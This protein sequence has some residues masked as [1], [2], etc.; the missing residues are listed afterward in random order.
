MSS[1][2]VSK[3]KEQRKLGYIVHNQNDCHS[4]VKLLKL[5]SLSLLGGWGHIVRAFVFWLISKNEWHH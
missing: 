3:G 1:V 5:F 4:R 2:C